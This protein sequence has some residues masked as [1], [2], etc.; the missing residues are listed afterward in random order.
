MKDEKEETLIKQVASAEDDEFAVQERLNA[1]EDFRQQF[2]DVKLRADEKEKFREL[3]EM[4]NAGKG[5]TDEAR[6]LM[7]EMVTEVAG[8][9]E[10]E[11]NREAKKR[12]ENL[13]RLMDD[14]GFWDNQPVP[15]TG[16][17]VAEDQYD[18]PIDKEKTVDDIPAEPYPL[19]AGYTWSNVDIHNDEEAKDVYELLTKHYVEDD[20]AHFRFDYSVPFLRWACSTP[21]SQPDM[22]FGVRGGKKN[23]LFG[24][25]AAIPLTVVVNGKKIEMVEINFLCVHKKLREKRLAP[26]L[27]KEV[28]RRTNRRN[29]WQAAYTAG[30][31]IPTPYS[32]TTYFHRC[33]NAKKCTDIQ[34]FHLPQNTTM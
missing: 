7:R 9:T 33:I 20:S 11:N 23:M 16:E 21:L 2:K 3:E 15:K 5:S 10:K 18:A 29:V 4:A 28:T 30:V 27:I 13:L 14:H 1:L 22:T 34:F 24:F 8:R 12:M 17:K 26:I 19:P 31:T 6:Q 25:I 32:D